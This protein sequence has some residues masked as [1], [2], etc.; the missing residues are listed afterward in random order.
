MTEVPG[1][2]VCFWHSVFLHP[3]PQDAPASFKAIARKYAMGNDQ[4]RKQIAG[5][6]YLSVMRGVLAQAK[7]SKNSNFMQQLADRVRHIEGSNVVNKY[8]SLINDVKLEVQRG[9]DLCPTQYVDALE[10]EH[11]ANM[12]GLR[13]LIY[14]IT[15]KRNVFANVITQ[16]PQYFGPSDGAQLVLK[17]QDYHYTPHSSTP[18][19]ATKKK[20]QKKN[21][22][23]CF[24]DALFTQ[25]LSDVQKGNTKYDKFRQ[26]AATYV[27]GNT[28]DR[29]SIV[30]RVMA[31]LGTKNHC[32]PSPEEIQKFAQTYNLL[33]SIRFQIKR[34]NGKLGSPMTLEYGPSKGVPVG[35][36]TMSAVPRPKPNKTPQPS[37]KIKNNNKKKTENQRPSASEPSVNQQQKPKFE[38]YNGRPTPAASKQVRFNT[39]NNATSTNRAPTANMPAANNSGNYMP[40]N[41]N[42]NFNNNNLSRGSGNMKFNHPNLENNFNMRSMANT[43]FDAI[44]GRYSVPDDIL[45]AARRY[46]LGSTAFEKPFREY[47]DGIPH[48]KGCDVKK[49]SRAQ[50]DVYHRAKVMVELSENVEHTHRG[51][52]IHASTGSGKTT[53]AMAIFL[54]YWRTG[55]T[56]YVITTKDNIDNNNPEQ[57]MKII[58]HFFPKH[59]AKLREKYP[60]PTN[61]EADKEIEKHIFLKVNSSKQQ[62]MKKINF[63]SL[64]IFA[65]KL[66]YEN[67]GTKDNIL[68]KKEEAV[69]V[70]DESHNLFQAL[71]GRASKGAPLYILQKLIDMTPEQR[72]NIHVYL[73]SATP[74]A[75]GITT[76]NSEADMSRE[77]DNWFKTFGIVAPVMDK[78][79]EDGNPYR[80][81]SKAFRTNN[82]LG[83]IKQ[84]IPPLMVYVDQRFDLSQHACV[85]DVRT[86]VKSTKWFY[87]AL[88]HDPAIKK[89]TH[90]Y[91]KSLAGVMGIKA[92]SIKVLTKEV[93]DVFKQKRMVVPILASTQVHDWLISPKAAALAK[94]VATHSGKHFIYV[95]DRQQANV[96]LHTINF[97]YKFRI[98]NP[99]TEVANNY[100]RY[101][102]MNN[103]KNS[104]KKRPGVILLDSG[105][106]VDDIKQIFDR[107]DIS[108][109]NGRIMSSNDNG[110]ICRA[111]IATGSM[112][113]GVN[114]QTIRY[115][116]MGSPVENALQEQQLSGRGVRLC[117]HERL[118]PSKR[119]VTVIRWFLEPPPEKSIRA[120]VQYLVKSGKKREIV[121]DLSSMLRQV[122][123]SMGLC[124]P[125]GLEYWARERYLADPRALAIWNFE[126]S[127][128]AVLKGRTRA[129]NGKRILVVGGKQCKK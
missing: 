75:S 53:M 118:P 113:E 96:L 16:I 42:G 28:T 45:E 54:A 81:M 122:Q 27:Q 48:S 120:M 60:A 106:M 97:L 17:L 46:G 8:Q 111:I 15:K 61:E 58:K 88:I 23:N 11:F 86:F 71:T 116:H 7:K 2:G 129:P 82:T 103:L 114:F 119:Q 56:M 99:A 77:F 105:R 76:T 35:P 121:E 85:N 100:H 49:L 47:I 34:P 72:R 91:M 63:V 14:F 43:L 31:E 89:P 70:F 20:Q 50:I 117:A 104:K 6:M 74:T 13:I 38:R 1:D 41:D 98:I 9:Q 5:N 67:K 25:P 83:F 33:I 55:R 107:H 95:K 125:K 36:I 39:Q 84:Y 21:N 62:K 18:F 37:F 124:A 19:G 59:Y 126:R 12:Y 65:H 29:N 40:F 87:G 3:V 123:V 93:L 30:R 51:L 64:E 79:F 68:R 101:Y 109:T 44:N 73:A 22:N 26:L 90:D 94:F 127:I 10:I 80:T 115:V 108:N 112:F 57:Y 4:E 32:R 24:W 69:V 52:L 78:Y 128:Q 66:G 110:D 92:K 102:Y